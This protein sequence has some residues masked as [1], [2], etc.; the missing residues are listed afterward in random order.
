MA[1]RLLREAVVGIEFA[2]YT[3]AEIRT[4]SVVRVTNAS[5]Y[6]T[7]GHATPGGLY[8]KA[9][10]PVR[11]EDGAC[12]TCALPHQECPGHFGHL[13]LSQPVYNVG[14]FPLMVALL[15]RACFSCHRLRALEK[16]EIYQ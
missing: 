5:T 10:G 8:D 11:Y 7:F 3:E 12:A 2:Y 9:L 1:A 4:A 6:D 16:P 15:K 14:L 13:E